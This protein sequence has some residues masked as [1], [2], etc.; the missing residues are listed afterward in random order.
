MRLCEIIPFL[1]LL[2]GA[3]AAGAV[4]IDGFF[5][6][7]FVVDGLCSYY[8]ASHSPVGEPH[9]FPG[10]GS[11][12]DFTGI[13]A[14]SGRN[15]AAMTVSSARSLDG[16]VSRI[17][18]GLFKNVRVVRTFSDLKKCREDDYYGVLFYKQS[19]W[20]LDG[21]L[22]NLEVW[23]EKGL[24]VF[25]MAYGSIDRVSA[26]EALGFGADEEGGLTELGREV[27]KELN[28]LHLVVDVSHCNDETTIDT[29]EASAFPVVATHANARG[30]TPND[31]NKSDMA[32]KA[33]RDSGGVV[34]V[35]TIGWMIENPRTKKQGVSEFVDHIDYLKKE[36][37]ID[38][39]GVS[40][41][42]LH[43]GWPADSRH[44]AC[45]ELAAPDRWTHV[46]RELVKRGYSEEE[47]KKI[48]SL[49]WLRVYRE[50]LDR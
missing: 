21:K 42:A 11:E 12:A 8:V 27:V 48:F 24:R 4:D 20:N 36:I 19:H 31:R 10:Q 46:A 6:G 25:Q 29:C 40:S 30:L 22:E 13:K 39:I 15:A 33:I 34:G 45:A 3:G 5:E 38:H 41:D 16:Q 28:R 47:M 18:R 1:I 37:G 49:N 23:K 14:E 9:P 44:H 43:N 17:D 32:L 50:V 2:A 26:E 35:N 7:N